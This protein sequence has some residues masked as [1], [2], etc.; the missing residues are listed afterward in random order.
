MQFVYYRLELKLN[1]KQTHLCYK[2]SGTSRFAY[3]WMLNNLNERIKH[4]KK[5][6]ADKGLS[7]INFRIGTAIDWHKE[8]VLLKNE[9]HWIRETSKCCGHEALRNLETAFKRF[10]SKTCRYPKFKKKGQK[11]SF[12]IGGLVYVTPTHIRIPT[13]GEI[14]LKEKFYPILEGIVKLSQVT[15]TR[16]A[17]RWFVSF[18]IKETEELPTLPTENEINESDIVGVDLGIKELA[19]TSDGQ[20]FENPRAYKSKLNKLKKY[21]RR[22]SRKQ[23]GSNNRKK[24]VMRLTRVHKQISDIRNDAVHKLT[25]SLVKAKP[26]ML[27]IES[28][29][30]KNMSKNHKLAGAIL[31]SSFGKI[32]TTLKYKC[33]LYGIHLI[34]APA[35]YASSK[36][37]SCCGHKNKELKLSDREWTCTNCNTHHDRDVNAAKNLQY[38]GLWMIDKHLTERS[39]TVSSTGSIACGDERLQFLTEQCSSLKQEFKQLYENK[40]V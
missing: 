2:S 32:K 37:C 13:F 16:H 22:V 9:L 6:S 3:N 23:K 39:T 19:I 31:D 35:F 38:F 1:K 18:L 28:L 15:V 30:P 36:Y 5:E 24:A 34:M 29:K 21:Q 17:D 26:K 7:K 25:T 27:V 33:E 4:S 8:W 40:V 12:R 10:F 14:R 20:T 11:D